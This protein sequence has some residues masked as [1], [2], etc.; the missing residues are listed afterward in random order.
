MSV[1]NFEFY[2][3]SFFFAFSLKF[4]FSLLQFLSGF[5]STRTHTHTPTFYQSW[6]IFGTLSRPPRI[7]G[8]KQVEV[9]EISQPTPSRQTIGSWIIRKSRECKN[10]LK[11]K[12][13]ERMSEWISMVWQCLRNQIGLLKLAKLFHNFKSLATRRVFYYSRLMGFITSRDMF[14]NVHKDNVKI[15]KLL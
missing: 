2:K 15:L 5:E 7:E 13:N 10:S 11:P 3:W 6:L 12:R 9:L 4:I 14:S 8:G 1:N